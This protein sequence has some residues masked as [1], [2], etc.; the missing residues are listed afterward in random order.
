MDF[1]TYGMTRIHSALV[2][3]RSFK[4]DK[5]SLDKEIDRKALE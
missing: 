4:N 2:N 1:S 5:I 3:R